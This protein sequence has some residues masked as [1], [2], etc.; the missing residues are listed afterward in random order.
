[1]ITTIIPTF[2]ISAFD[3]DRLHRALLSIESQTLLPHQILIS[4]D[5]EN[6]EWVQKLFLQLSEYKLPLR[7]IRNSGESN[8]SKN[9]NFA[10]S[11]AMGEFL[12]ILHQDDWIINTNFYAETLDA[13]SGQGY[14]WSLAIGVTDGR[15]NF[16]R[17][18]KALIFGFNSIGGPS[19]LVIKREEWI[20]LDDNYLL[21]PDVVHFT[22]LRRK[23]GPPYISKKACIEYGIGK[24]K[25]TNRITHKEIEADIDQLLHSGEVKGLPYWFLQIR[26]GF[27]GEHLQIIS[28]HI[29]RSDL[30]KFSVRVQA[31]ML[32]LTCSLA[33]YLIK[34]KMFIFSLRP[35]FHTHKCL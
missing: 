24:H 33:S 1:M 11:E 13:L 15:I 8:A 17:F 34:V 26:S 6:D 16:P 19:A 35:K 12:H 10:V 25:L 29:Y 22:Q 20:P 21:L 5:T 7:Y 14:A 18:N 2:I 9:T 23:L 31:Y 4:D 32:S 30:V 28:R 27:W 3:L